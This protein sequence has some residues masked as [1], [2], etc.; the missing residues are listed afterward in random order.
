MSFFLTFFRRGL[1]LSVSELRA[2]D[3]LDLQSECIGARWCSF[4]LL[5]VTNALALRHPVKAPKTGVISLRGRLFH[6][7]IFGSF[8]GTAE[9]SSGCLG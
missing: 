1:F 4:F 2:F 6:V 3:C 8:P 7:S 9:G 5:I